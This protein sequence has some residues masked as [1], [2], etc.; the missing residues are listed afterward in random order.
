ASIRL[1]LVI[2]YDGTRYAGWQVQKV[3]LGVQQRVEE[4]LARIFPSVRRI[5]GSSRTDTG[6]HALGMVAHV[7]VRAA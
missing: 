2:A 5:H 7:D 4:A 1:K 3:G 6:V